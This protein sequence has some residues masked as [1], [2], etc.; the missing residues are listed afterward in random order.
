MR[1]VLTLLMISVLTACSVERQ[2]EDYHFQ[3]T[4]DLN[5]TSANHVHGYT[6]TECFSCHLPQNIHQVDRLGAPN[7]NLAQPSVEAY[8][9]SS[10]RG[11][12][13]KNGVEP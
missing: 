7:F 4:A 8:G 10:C 2:T 11:C 12:H 3:T 1:Y 13:G 5:L 6:R 9:L